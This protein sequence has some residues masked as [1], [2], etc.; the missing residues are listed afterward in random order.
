MSF[1]CK[2]QN[3]LVD[4]IIENSYN[5]KYILHEVNKCN[6]DYWD[7]LLEIA[8]IVVYKENKLKVLR[9][10]LNEL[11]FH[12]VLS[13]NLTEFQVN[14]K[15]DSITMTYKNKDLNDFH[16]IYTI[17]VLIYILIFNNE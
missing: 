3:Q 13:K 2:K 5:I 9:A 14:M 7:F 10:H 12:K 4:Q 11:G 8:F 1:L 15:K 16:R 6:F 17:Y